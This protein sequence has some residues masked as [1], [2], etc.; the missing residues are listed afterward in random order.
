MTE[1]SLVVSLA[2]QLFC[3]QYDLNT[4]EIEVINCKYEILLCLEKNELDKCF[5][6]EEGENK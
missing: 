1:L 6:N 2:I 5:D 3:G 4:T